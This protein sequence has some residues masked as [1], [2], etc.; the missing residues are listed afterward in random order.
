M[1]TQCGF[2]PFPAHFGTFGLVPSKK[3][4]VNVVLASFVKETF[5]LERGSAVKA[6]VIELVE[7]RVR[8][9]SDENGDKYSASQLIEQSIVLR[10]KMMRY[11][12][13]CLVIASAC[14]GANNERF[15]Y[16]ENGTISV[17]VAPWLVLGFNERGLLSLVDFCDA[18]NALVLPHLNTHT[19]ITGL[20]SVPDGTISIPLALLTN[21][22]KGVY[23]E[24][25][26]RNSSGRLYVALCLGITDEES[27]T[28][29][30]FTDGGYIRPVFNTS[31]A[32]TIKGLDGHVGYVQA[33]RMKRTKTHCKAGSDLNLQYCYAASSKHALSNMQR[34]V[35]NMD[36][37]ISPRANENV[38]LGSDDNYRLCLVPRSSDLKSVF[39]LK[40]VPKSF[41][42]DIATQQ[43]L[44][45]KPKKS[46]LTST[47]DHVDVIVMGSSNSG[48]TS[49]IRQFLH[50]PFGTIIKEAHGIGTWSIPS[51]SS[52]LKLRFKEMYETEQHDDILIKYVTYAHVALIMYDVTDQKSYKRAQE[53]LQLVLCSAPPSLITVLVG[54]KKDL[55][56]EQVVGSHRAEDLAE[57]HNVLFKE[58]S[59]C[60]GNSAMN[61]L[62]IVSGSVD[63]EVAPP[64]V[65]L[66]ERKAV[67]QTIEPR[68]GW[69]CP[70]CTDDYPSP[71]AL[72]EHLANQHET[73][74][75]TV[76]EQS[77]S[78]RSSK[79]V[80]RRVQTLGM[81]IDHRS[82]FMEAVKRINDKLSEE[83]TLS[84]DVLCFNRVVKEHVITECKEKYE[85][86]V[87]PFT[88]NLT[89]AFCNGCGTKIHFHAP[90]HRKTLTL[91]K[92]KT[93]SSSR[94]ATICQLC[95]ATICEQECKREVSIQMCHDISALS[96]IRHAFQ[97]S[98]ET[99]HLQEPVRK[100]PVLEFSSSH[101]TCCVNCLK[102]SEDLYKKEKEKNN[103][104]YSRWRDHKHLPPVSEFH[105]A[106]ITAQE[107][108]SML[109]IEYNALYTRLIRGGALSKYEHAQ[110]LYTDIKAIVN[111]IATI[112]QQIKNL[113]S[114]PHTGDQQLKRMILA[115]SMSFQATMLI[116]S[117][118]SIK[119]ITDLQIRNMTTFL[120]PE[121]QT[122]DLVVNGAGE[123]EVW[124]NQRYFPIVKW[125]RTPINGNQSSADPGPWST[126]KVGEEPNTFSRAQLYTY[127][128]RRCYN[129]MKEIQP[130]AGLV[131]VG[132]WYIST[133][134]IG[135]TEGWMYNTHFDP[136]G[137]SAK[138]TLK[139]CRRRKWC[140]AVTI[141]GA[142][143][144]THIQNENDV[145][146]CTKCFLPFQGVKVHCG[147]CG[148]VVCKNCSSTHRFKEDSNR[149]VPCC[150]T[151][152]EDF[153]DGKKSV[154]AAKLRT[155]D[156][157][158]RE[159]YENQRK[160]IVGWK[161]SLAIGRHPYSDVGGGDGVAILEAVKPI[162]GFK[163]VSL[164]WHN[165]KSLDVDDD[166][167]QYAFSWH[168]SNWQ[169]TH[170]WNS[171]VRR[172]RW[173]RKMGPT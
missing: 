52:E 123:M 56:D 42:E 127:M 171:N 83:H 87:L 53:L 157:I 134:H 26:N 125:T 45:I 130:Y 94:K 49:L 166:G 47:D 133:E 48:K 67:Y 110:K 103:F 112:Q 159:I 10:V 155:S 141:Q 106:L 19:P 168:N 65:E 120:I 101:V 153:D 164:E 23:V 105:N 38:V 58:V 121:L 32:L 1:A 97:V 7:D 122:S 40:S 82:R 162:P 74:G 114:R 96:E 161:P 30:Y 73:H 167:W 86:N 138:S 140:R 95:S 5:Q 158:I 4:T 8:L 93:V 163:F 79:E 131:W 13:G 151:C 139:C 34:F 72:K 91:M 2:A 173:I 144:A 136:L 41:N 108:Q 55:T 152:H 37:T 50:K 156:V 109:T 102:H 169:N 150:L 84:K 57:E 31:L 22:E 66:M 18:T 129:T 128:R 90:A 143:K 172:R 12:I 68:I 60:Q 76:N 3:T 89:S 116:I 36:G 70:A 81:R 35:T 39:N 154:D 17:K 21:P 145:D 149:K 165:D 54:N 85:P 115:A 46:M 71:Q 44:S 59:C 113:A 119:T 25:G 6:V 11:Q 148:W 61:V 69:N 78:K 104:L 28:K 77:K 98:Y 80:A 99:T 124:E 92:T 29:W 43:N 107:N 64:F 132:E 160:T 27:I 117:P 100:G 118:P 75:S 62:D 126:L 147:F 88:P 16:N 135:C 170:R 51:V 14:T 15:I 142:L 63:P 20:P 111:D 146:K 33:F 24:S 9:W 137:W